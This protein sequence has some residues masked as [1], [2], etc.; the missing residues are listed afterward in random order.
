MCVYGPV[1]F[2]GIRRS[3][4]VVAAGLAFIMHRARAF[5]LASKLP[6]CFVRPEPG[7]IFGSSKP[8][9]A[10]LRKPQLDTIGLGSND[11]FGGKPAGS[12]LRLATAKSPKGGRKKTQ[13]GKKS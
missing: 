8:L 1:T 9:W 3:A 10:W 7:S 12:D 13:G 6:P 11:N 2:L 5:A 4:V